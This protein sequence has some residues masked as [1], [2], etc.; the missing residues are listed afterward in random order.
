M[1]A[2]TIWSLSSLLTRGSLAPCATNSG[3]LILSA[4]IAGEVAA[5]RSWSRSGSPTMS[6]ILSSIGFQYGGMDF[7]NVNRFDTPT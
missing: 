2:A 5:R 7:M 1:S 3:V 6:C 4:C